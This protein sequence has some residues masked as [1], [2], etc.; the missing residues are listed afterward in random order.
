V[1]RYKAPLGLRFERK[2]ITKKFT[3]G[4]FFGERFINKMNFKKDFEITPNV[5]NAYKLG[6]ITPISEETLGFFLNRKEG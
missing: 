4:N 1:I 3:V 5:M 6:F 2:H